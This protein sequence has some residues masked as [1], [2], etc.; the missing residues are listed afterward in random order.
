MHQASFAGKT[1]SIVKR[2]AL[3]HVQPDAVKCQLSMELLHV[4]NCSII[5]TAM[6]KEVGHPNQVACYKP[7]ST[8]RWLVHHSC[9]AGC[10]KSG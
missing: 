5:R 8:L 10:V 1:A 4:S 9:A 3:I 6:R 2:G 7:P